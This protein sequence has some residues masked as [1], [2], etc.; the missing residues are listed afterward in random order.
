MEI[1]DIP[2]KEILLLDALIGIIK[3]YM[4]SYGTS[5]Y[6]HQS[7]KSGEDAS[8]VL[9]HYGISDDDGHSIVF[10]ESKV[11]QITNLAYKIHRSEVAVL[12]AGI[13]SKQHQEP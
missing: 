6:A 5:T 8:D 10:D 4:P 3:Q 11:D 7:M 2:S 1:K 9:M 13:Q 12:M